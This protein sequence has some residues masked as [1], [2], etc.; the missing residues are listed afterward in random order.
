MLCRFTMDQPL[1]WKQNQCRSCYKATPAPRISG[2]SRARG[3]GHR[4]RPQSPWRGSWST[5][6]PSAWVQLTHL[7]PISPPFSPN[8]WLPLKNAME[9]DTP[10]QAGVCLTFPDEC[11]SQFCC[12]TFCSQARVALLWKMM[13]KERWEEFLE[14]TKLSTVVSLHQGGTSQHLTYT[15]WECLKSPDLH[16]T[17]SPPLQ[18]RPCVWT[19][20]QQ[21]GFGLCTY[22]VAFVSHSGGIGFCFQEFIIKAAPEW[23]SFELF[24]GLLTLA[25]FLL[26]Y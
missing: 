19:L 18:T 10:A 11:P 17:G 21:K 23:G 5:Q 14:E 9:R 25:L 13:P 22:G 1:N 16:N 4:C 26:S 20:P 8:F 7:W 12:H 24:S 15:G 2:G 6:I 3:R